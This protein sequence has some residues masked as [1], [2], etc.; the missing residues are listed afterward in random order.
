MIRTNERRIRNLET[1]MNPKHRAF[2]IQI[3]DDEC[4]EEAKLRAGVGPD[5]TAFII[6]YPDPRPR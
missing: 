6:H 5:D 4:V 2:F 1:A 3:Y